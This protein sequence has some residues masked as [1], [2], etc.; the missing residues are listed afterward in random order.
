MPFINASQDQPERGFQDVDEI[1][2]SEV[3]PALLWMEYGRTKQIVIL[4]NSSQISG[5]FGDMGKQEPR[6]Y[7]ALQGLA[8]GLSY[9]EIGMWLDRCLEQHIVRNADGIK[10][11]IYAEGEPAHRLDPDKPIYSF[12]GVY[13]RGLVVQEQ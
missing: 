6:K 5:E 8:A 4:P 3:F 2:T 7:F 13:S 1:I 9:P 12:K 10:R 11:L